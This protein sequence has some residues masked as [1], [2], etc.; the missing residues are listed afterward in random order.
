MSITSVFFNRKEIGTLVASYI[1]TS[2]YRSKIQ[3]SWK[4]KVGDNEHCVEFIIS[5]LTG[6]RRVFLDGKM[7]FQKRMYCI[8]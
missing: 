4:F 7:V 8:E 6:K 3:Y 2:K 5:Y 1:L